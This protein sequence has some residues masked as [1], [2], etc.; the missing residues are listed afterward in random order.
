MVKAGR[1]RQP[2]R[3]ASPLGHSGLQTPDK[4]GFIT[5]G[6]PPPGRF[7]LLRDPSLLNVPKLYRFLDERG[8]AEAFCRGEIWTTT[9]HICRHR[10]DVARADRGE[11]KHTYKNLSVVAGSASDPKVQAVVR[12]L[13]LPP[14]GGGRVSLYANLA[15]RTMPD[16]HLLCLSYRSDAEAMSKF[17]KYCIEIS[18]PVE[19]FRH[20]SYATQ[21]QRARMSWARIAPVVYRPREYCDDEPEPGMMGF[22]K[23]ESYKSEEEVR[24]L[25]MPFDE[26]PIGPGLLKSPEAGA[27]CRIIAG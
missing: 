8:H 13:G 2:Y 12:K 9:L 1:G 24:L 6:P 21:R 17:G 27:L 14:I 16:T 3:R 11:G 22:V 25:W 23:P 5:L 7:H 19:F 18:Q 26:G 15:E 10:E 4:D 20:L